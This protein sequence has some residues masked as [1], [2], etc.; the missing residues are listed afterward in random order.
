MK[1]LHW[2]ALAY[3]LAW[4]TMLKLSLGFTTYLVIRIFFRIIWKGLL[5]FGDEE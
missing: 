4:V 5:H 3:S 1:I 2:M